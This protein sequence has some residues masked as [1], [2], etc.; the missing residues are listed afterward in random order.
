MASKGKKPYS[1]KGKKK[2]GKEEVKLLADRAA[3]RAKGEVPKPMPEPMPEPKSAPGPEEEAYDPKAATEAWRAA[4]TI[5]STEREKKWDPSYVDQV[6]RLCRL[7]MTDTEIALFF[8]IKIQTF[9]MWRAKHPDF[10]A[11]LRTGREFAHERV[12]RAAYQCAVGFTIQEIKLFHHQGMVVEHPVDVY[13]PPDG[14]LAMRWLES[15]RAKKWANPNKVELSGPGGKPVEIEN[16]DSK[17]LAK[18]I[19]FTLLAGLPQKPV[20][21]AT[22]TEVE[23]AK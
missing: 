20:I 13:Y 7:G 18:R 22:A 16:M 14:K 21:E 19:A 17:E 11:A 8:E 6:K 3:A 4:S 10:V 9:W 1:P 15:A 23:P 5:R 2:P 12:E